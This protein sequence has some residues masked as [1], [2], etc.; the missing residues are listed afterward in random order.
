[1]LNVDLFLKDSGINIQ[2]RSFKSGL[3]RI[4]VQLHVPIEIV[5]PTFRCVSDSDRDGDNRIPAR[6]DGFS[7]QSHVR[8][9]R[10]SSA[11]PIIATP[12]GRDNILPC[13]FTPLGDRDDMIEGQIFGLKLMIAIL[14]GVTVPGEDIDP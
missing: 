10:G 12:T 9:V 3:S 7:G 14:A 1:M 6:L 2:H 5:P 11:F 8:F 4:C 13:L